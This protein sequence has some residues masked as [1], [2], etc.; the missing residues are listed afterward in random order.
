MIRETDWAN[1]FTFVLKNLPDYS[2]L[3]TETINAREAGMQCN[4]SVNLGLTVQDKIHLKNCSLCQ[5]TLAIMV[6]P[7]MWVKIVCHI[8]NS[9]AKKLNN[10]Y[11]K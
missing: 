6:Q 10:P 3:F 9:C 11:L 8:R 1:M 2:V 4:E 7:I 5:G